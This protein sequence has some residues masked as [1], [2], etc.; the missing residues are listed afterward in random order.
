M[1][2]NDPS[3][4]SVVNM[5]AP[6][7]QRGRPNPYGGK[8][9]PNKTNTTDKPVLRESKKTSVPGVRPLSADGKAKSAPMTG[10]I[11]IEESITIGK[12]A[13]ELYAFWRDFRNLPLFCKYL[14]DVTVVDEKTS[15]WT[16]W[17][18]AD[19]PLSW[20]A[21]LIQ[22]TPDELISWRTFDSSDFVNAGSVRFEKAPGDRGTEVHMSFAYNPP[23]GPI[24][25]LVAKLTAKD[26]AFLMREQLRR[27]K[28]LM[29]TGEIATTE[30]QPVLIEK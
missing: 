28:Q 1:G 29:E 17:G 15:H 21:T 9:M 5:R 13:S 30:G 25:S 3:R 19:K 16:A 18:P 7:T 14:R 20:D 11:L 12:P 23:G 2:V 8:T 6:R 10:G 22:D 26:P 27:F 4:E 24:G